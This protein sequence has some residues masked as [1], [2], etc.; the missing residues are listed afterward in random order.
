MEEEFIITGFNQE[1]GNNAGCVVWQCKLNDKKNP[2]PF[3]FN[4]KPGGPVDKRR[5]YFKKADKYIGKKLTVKFQDY[6]EKSGIPRFPVGKAIRE[7]Y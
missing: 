3:K 6:H 2:N 5:E 1:T 4:V 7:G